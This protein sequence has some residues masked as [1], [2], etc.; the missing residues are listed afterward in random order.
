M[1]RL[2]VKHMAGPVEGDLLIPN[3]KYHAHRAL[4]LAALAPGLSRIEGLSDAGHVRH[5]IAAL[6]ALGTKITT[7]GQTFLVRGGQF[8]PAGPRCPWAAQGRRCTS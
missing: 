4:I 8:R 2:I 7:D 1:M 5:T 3:S 6:R